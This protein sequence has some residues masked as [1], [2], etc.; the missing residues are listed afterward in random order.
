[1]KASGVPN[2]PC[3]MK[4]NTTTV[5]SFPQ[6]SPEGAITRNDMTAIEQL[7]LWLTYQRHFCEHKPS[8]TVTVRD[9]EWVEVGAW[10]FKHFDEV[11]GISFLPHSDHTYKQAPYQECSEREYLDMLSLMPDVIEWSDLKFYEIEDSTTGSQTMACVAGS[12]EIV[13]LTH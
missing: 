4:P 10:V 7:E 13:D 8:V 12:C 3:V 2:E 6:K 1:M 9:D 11:S 5:F